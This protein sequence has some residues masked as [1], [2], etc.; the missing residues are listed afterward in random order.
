MA[1][2]GRGRNFSFNIENLGFGR[3]ESLPGPTVQPPPIF[4]PL[5]TKPVPLATGDNYD[6]MLALKQEFRTT[7]RDSPFFIKTSRVK[8][9]IERYTDK[10]QINGNGD[11]SREW[12]PMW[13][14]LPKEL[15]IRMKKSRKAKAVIKP[16]ILLNDK[17]S[18]KQVDDV[19]NSLEV[20][21][22]QEVKDVPPEESEEKKANEQ[23]EGEEEEI[24]DEDYD[25]EDMEEGTDYISSYFDNGESFLDD[26]EENLDD[27]P[28][29]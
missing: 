17:K 27:G 19:L 15:H 29:Y 3:G 13:H 28:I 9:D 4:P 16:K 22:E 14:R 23:T 8:K 1:G 2:R 6:Y 18:K 11:S 5:E 21:E 7:M 10:Y 26:E 20:L 12:T 24:D 25:E